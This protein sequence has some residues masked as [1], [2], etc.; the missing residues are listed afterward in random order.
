MVP[1]KIDENTWF[2]YSVANSKSLN[3]LILIHVKS[4][5]FLKNQ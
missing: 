2:L 4:G 5:N 1:L 3:I